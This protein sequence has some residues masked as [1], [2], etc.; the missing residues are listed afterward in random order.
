MTTFRG[1]IAIDITPT[2]PIQE[3][4]LEI[5]KSH[6]DVKL[7]DTKNIHITLKFLGDVDQSLTSSIITIMDAAVKQVTPFSIDL[8]GSGVFPNQNYIKV[9]WI[10][11]QPT[12]ELPQLVKYLENA[13][14]PLGFNKESRSFSPHLT[15]GRVRTPR[16][17]PQL[18][19]IITQYHS[20]HFGQQNITA[21]Y[22]KQSTLTPHGPIYTILHEARM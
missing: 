10:G 14:E 17:K 18:L 15:I 22:L 1:F 8:Q 9:I 20:V 2:E 19:S 11:I 21:I 7:V 4:L 5:H 16:N 3:I 6:A 12:E 13:L